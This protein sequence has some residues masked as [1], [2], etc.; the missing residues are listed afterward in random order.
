MVEGLTSPKIFGNCLTLPRRGSQAEFGQTSALVLILVG[1]DERF[2]RR[3]LGAFDI[4]LQGV[5]DFVAC[6]RI[7]NKPNGYGCD[8]I[9]RT[10]RIKE[11]LKG[12]L[13]RTGG[14]V[15]LSHGLKWRRSAHSGQLVTSFA[16]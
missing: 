10:V 9:G 5:G 1:F 8:V 3:E 6:G 15:I 4:D 13:F 2:E 16:H 7:L 11:G 14:V 12:V